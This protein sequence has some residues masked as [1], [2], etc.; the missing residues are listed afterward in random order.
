[1]ETMSRTEVL[2]GSGSSTPLGTPWRLLWLLDGAGASRSKPG[3]ITTM[4]SIDLELW[5]S[6]NCKITILFSP[7]PGKR[8]CYF[9]SHTDIGRFLKAKTLLKFRFYCPALLRW[10]EVNLHD[11]AH[12][13]ECATDDKKNLEQIKLCFLC[14]CLDQSCECYSS[15]CYFVTRVKARGQRLPQTVSS[16]LLGFGVCVN[17]IGQ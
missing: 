10:E 9:V 12:P 17:D 15:Y 5:L 4:F 16:C 3:G 11:S 8:K 7:L 6:E 14:E 2:S 13:L 1:M